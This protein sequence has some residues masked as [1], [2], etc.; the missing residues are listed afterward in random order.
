MIRTCFPKIRGINYQLSIMNY[1][2]RIM[3]VCIAA[4]LLT[5]AMPLRASNVVPVPSIEGQKLLLEIE[6]S[7]R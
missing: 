1:E 4:V 3:N 5:V 7:W 6:D 2:L